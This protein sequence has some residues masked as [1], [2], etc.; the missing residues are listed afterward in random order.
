MNK[1]NA[2]YQALLA[3]LLVG[4]GLLL[5][6]G[7][8]GTPAATG[9][10]QVNMAVDP[11]SP[12]INTA[13]FTVTVRDAQGQPVDGAQVSINAVHPTMGHGGPSGTLTA[14]GGGNYAARG[15]FTMMG[16]WKVTVT[17]TKTG[18]DSVTK[19]FEVAVQ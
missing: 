19:D 2:G 15:N 16:T 5:L 18:F 7:C 3:R 17:V 12:G 10:L 4:L 6:A 13:T 9:S 1:R 8:T 11:P 14:Q